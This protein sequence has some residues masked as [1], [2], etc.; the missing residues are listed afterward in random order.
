MYNSGRRIIEAG[1][2]AGKK[3]VRRL[4]KAPDALRTFRSRPEAETLIGGNVS[5]AVGGD[6]GCLRGLA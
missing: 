1:A 3:S 2:I 6:N 4:E 5:F